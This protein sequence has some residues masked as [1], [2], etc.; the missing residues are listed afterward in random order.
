MARKNNDV[1]LQRS[2]YDISSAADLEEELSEL[3]PGEARIDL[4][5]VRYMDSNALRVMMLTAKKIGGNKPG[6]VR[7]RGVTPS[8]RRI[9]A[10]VTSGQFFT[11]ED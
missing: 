1:L 6:A 9:I 4:S 7:L 10:V 5:N 2:E 3:E 11:I 8:M